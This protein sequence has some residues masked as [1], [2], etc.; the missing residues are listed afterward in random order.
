[1]KVKVTVSMLVLL[2]ATIFLG[3]SGIFP[4]LIVLPADSIILG[5]SIVAVLLFLPIILLSKASIRV[6]GKKNIFLVVVIGLL[7][8]GHWVFFYHSIKLSTVAIAVILIFTYP[9]MSAIIEPIW[10]KNKISWMDCYFSALV[11]LSVVVMSGEQLQGLDIKLGVVFGLISACCL[12]VRNVV[13]KEIN[14]D[15][16]AISLMFYQ[17]LITLIVLLPV[18][19]MPLLQATQLDLLLVIT[20]GLTSSVIGHT[21]FVKSLEYYSA[22]IVGIVSSFQVVHASVVAW[23]WLSEPLTVR[24]VI[25]GGVIIY[26]VIHQLLQKKRKDTPLL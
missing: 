16:N 11:I 21:L 2:L 23:L 5:R 4:K 15:I 25:G 12:A 26:V 24:V 6:A 7:M 8:A 10:N 18:A 17:N 19:A 14:N 20:V 13:I 3:F 1:M 22:T 9:M